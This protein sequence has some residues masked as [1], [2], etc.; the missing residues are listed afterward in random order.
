M[1]EVSNPGGIDIHTRIVDE[2]SVSSPLKHFAN[3]GYLNYSLFLDTDDESP[4]DGYY[5]KWNSEPNS[6]D[7]YDNLEGDMLEIP[8]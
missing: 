8:K 6:I 7:V 2:K 5:F 1:Y 4:S 3:G